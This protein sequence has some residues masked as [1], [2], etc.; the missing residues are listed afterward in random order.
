MMSPNLFV[1]IG[2]KP[3]FLVAALPGK[4]ILAPSSTALVQVQGGG[5]Q[6]PAGGDLEADGEGGVVWSLQHPPIPPAGATLTLRYPHLTLVLRPHPTL[7]PTP[8]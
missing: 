5:W 1:Q 7:T 3:K 6:F 4:G 2:A 8:G